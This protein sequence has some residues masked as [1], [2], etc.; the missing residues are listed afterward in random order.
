[1]KHFFSGIIKRDKLIDEAALPKQLLEISNLIISSGGKCCLVGGWVRDSLL[2]LSSKDYDVEVYGL[3]EKKLLKILSKYGRPNTVGRSFGVI[4]LRIGNFAFD[5]SFPRTEMKKGKGHRGFLVEPDS[6][7]SFEEASER[8]DFTINA[9]GV[10]LPERNILDA[11]QGLEDLEAR[12]LKHVGDAFGEDPLRV[13]RAV[14]FVARFALN[15]KTETINICK[16]QD[17]SE[18]SKERF[19]EEFSKWLL[20]SKKPSLGLAIMA[21]M[22]VFR[23]FPELDSLDGDFLPWIERLL[24]LDASVGQLEKL[25][26]IS[27]D[28]KELLSFMMAT[29]LSH[30]VEEK[31]VRQGIERISQDIKLNA[32]VIL[33]FSS[34]KKALVLFEKHK[35]TG[36]IIDGDVRRLALYSHSIE[37]LCLLL[38]AYSSILSKDKSDEFSSFIIKLKLQAKEFNIYKQAPTALLTG[39][40]LID[41]GVKPGKKMGKLIKQSFELQLDGNLKNIEDV[42]QWLSTLHLS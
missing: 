5:F 6:N 22:D 26:N 27:N 23:F 39:K 40:I 17:L 42:E 28:E 38:N 18:L 25:K 33:F 7:L 10:T 9:M 12:C 35:E 2:G 31:N 30:K 3:S 11:H 8:R 19:L 4:V 21:E 32:L 14:Q 41:K 36:K 37:K 16:E 20:K 1:M 15:V 34:F 13:L 24:F 29:L